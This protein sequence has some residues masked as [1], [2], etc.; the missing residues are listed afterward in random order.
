MIFGDNFYINEIYASDIGRKYII[1][2][3]TAYFLITSGEMTP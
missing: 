3:Y 2:F 1:A